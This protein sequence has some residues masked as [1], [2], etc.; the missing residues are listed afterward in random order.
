MLP[1]ERALLAQ[2][3]ERLRQVMTPEAYET[4]WKAGRVV[5]EAEAIAEVLGT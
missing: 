1:V 2:T 4:E 5:P 3:G